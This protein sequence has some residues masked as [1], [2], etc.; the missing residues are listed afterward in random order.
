MKTLLIISSLLAVSLNSFARLSDGKAHLTLQGAKIVGA[1]D[2]GF[3]FNKDAPAALVIGS[4][5][6]EP[7]KKDPKEVIFDASKVKSQ[8]FSVNFYVC[9]DKNT[10]CESHEYA[11]AIQSGKLVA[12]EVNAAV[13]VVP[14]VK[15]AVTSSAVAKSVPFKKNKHGFYQD[16]LQEAL[17]LAKDS[18]KLLVVDFG[19][20]WC[21]SCIRLE[22]EVFGEKVFQKA[23]E[24][25]IKVSINVDRADNKDLSKKY[26]I[27]VIPT[28]IV[29]N[30]QGE[31]LARLMDYK[32]A[33]VLAKDLEQIQT[34]QLASVEDLKKKAE[35]G[36]AAARRA[37]GQRAFYSVNFEEAAKWLAPLNEPS[38]MLANCEVN[39]GQ[40]KYEEDKA[41]NKDLY[42]KTLEKWIAAYPQG[43]EAI[44]WR[45]EL[46]KVLKGEGK[47]VTSAMKNVGEKNIADIQA[48]LN[49]DQARS[50]AFAKTL[51]GDYTGFEKMELLSQLTESY[52]LLG[53]KAKADEAK[54]LLGKEVSAM[55][56]SEKRPGQVLVALGYMRQAGQKTAMVSWLEKLIK[57]YPK[58]D[59]YYTKL[60]R[61]Y[62]REKSF[63]KALPYAQKAAEIKSDLNL[64]NLKTLAEVHKDLKQNKEASEVVAKALA[65][66]EA[67]LEQNKKTVA[68]LEEL[69]K[70]LTQ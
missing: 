33:A 65:L 57:A 25:L 46:L 14:S 60:A 29:M 64:Y 67:Q 1:V 3:H 37:M 35:A 52:D 10:V 11:Y 19:A 63:D 7:L 47:E 69:K 68:A 24:K 13:K 61:Y 49:S 51:S 20:P 39:L 27:K 59:V 50:E 58:T 40:E 18:K 22:T 41:K 5:S 8:S 53:N 54:T 31:E 66:P 16:N 48:L 26:D 70:S 43:V 42:Q 30:A 15:S 21:P 36:D 12:A 56:L 17:K 34:Q 32:P 6:V 4:E 23:T 28:L 55:S 38:L 62:I 2:S 44:V 45:G 9:D